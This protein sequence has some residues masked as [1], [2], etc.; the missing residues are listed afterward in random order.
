MKRTI[1][2]LILFFVV[3][4]KSQSIKQ[5][6]SLNNQIC[7]SFEKFNSLDESKL[8]E[9]LQKHMPDFYTKYKI[10]TKTKSDSIMDLV[11]F[12]LQKNCDAFL[13]LLSKVEQNKSD[14]GMSEEKPKNDINEQDL[15]NFFSFKKLHYKEYDGKIVMVNND[16]NLWSEKFEDGSFSKLELKKTSESTFVLKFIE[17]NNE[18]RKNFSVKGEEFKYGIYGKGQNYYSAWV[19]SKEGKYYTF[20]LYVD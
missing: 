20:K 16:S 14:W 11:Y 19:L 13:D 18:M 7:K 6:D 10:D 2:F 9:V 3:S 12:R 4:A 8:H 17:S 15:K 5:I 1:S